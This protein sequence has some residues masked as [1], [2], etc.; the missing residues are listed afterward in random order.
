MTVPLARVAIVVRGDGQLGATPP[1][2]ARLAPIF[3]ALS[4][5]GL[6]A[7]AV[8]FDDQAA[9]D[10]RTKLAGYD[11]AVVWVD[12]ISND[13][14]RTRLD[15][16]LLDVA[17]NGV[18]VSTH[19]DVILKMGTKEV[20]YRTR[21]LGWGTDT[22]LYASADEL[23]EQ[24]PTRLATSGPRVLKQ[25]RGNGGQGVW[26]VQLVRPDVV[27]VQHAQIREAVSEELSLSR[28]MSR[29]EEYFG[30]NAGEGRLIDQSF[31]PRIVEGLVRCY[32]VEDRV[33]G[34]ARQYAQGRSPAE[35]QGAGATEAT[36]PADQVFGLPSAKTMFP[37]HEPAYAALRRQLE[38]AW[39]P[40]MQRLVDVATSSLPLLW[41]ADFLF[42][43]PTPDGQDTYV[44]GEINVSC[45][46]PFPDRAPTALAQGLLARL[47]RPAADYRGTIP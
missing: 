46:I 4:R 32:L 37:A 35:P 7:D 33:V 16:V 41:D 45:V 26:K 25:Y 11:A 20:L 24:F 21:E 8:V 1:Q 19:P 34:F 6:A 13:A 22:H 5:E 38:T 14:D 9:A 29:C 28:F 3:E 31:Q 47:Q 36:P 43:P 40:G 30:A 27:R 39:L 44:L 18:L 15:E 42:G 2:V 23:R 10:V 17:A 12:P